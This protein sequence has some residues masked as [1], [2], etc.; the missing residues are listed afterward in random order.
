MHASFTGRYTRTIALT[1]CV[2][3]TTP[4]EATKHQSATDKCNCSR[5]LDELHGNHQTAK[6]H[7]SPTVRTPLT[8]ATVHDHLTSCMATI[9]QRNSTTHQRSATDECNC[10]RPLDA[11][12]GNHQTA[13]QHNSPTVFTRCHLTIALATTDGQVQ[14]ARHLTTAFATSDGQVRLVMWNCHNLIV[15]RI[16]AQLRHGPE[17]QN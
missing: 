8:S 5:P 11:L 16:S 7:N 14:L 12:P 13:K 3:S 4:N 1:Q 9:K 10:S 17:I 15:M 6:Q 2:P